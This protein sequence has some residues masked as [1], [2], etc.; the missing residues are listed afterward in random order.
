MT[1][2]SNYDKF[3]FVSVGSEQECS[4]GW[5]AIAAQLTPHLQ[6][7]SVLCVECYPGAFVDQIRAGL[8]SAFPASKVLL[9][10][11]CLKTPRKLRAMLDPLLGTDRVFG[12]MSRIR[13]EDYFD[14]QRLVRMRAEVAREAENAPV[15]VLGAGASFISPE[16]AVVVYADMARW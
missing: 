1:R 15:I 14:S 12:H 8:L 2:L 9:S 16:N 10:E 4:V 11:D 13:L 7:H 5:E 3:P 6:P